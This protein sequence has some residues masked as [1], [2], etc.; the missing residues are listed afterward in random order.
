MNGNKIIIIIMIIITICLWFSEQLHE[1][2][3][4]SLA[5]VIC[6]N[7]DNIRE[8]QPLVFLD[9]DPFLWDLTSCLLHLMI[10]NCIS[11]TIN[12]ILENTQSGCIPVCM[13]L[14]YKIYFLLTFQNLAFSFTV[15]I[16]ILNYSI[17]I[18][19]R[20]FGSTA[21]IPNPKRKFSIFYCSTLS[22][23]IIWTV[24]FW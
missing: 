10:M 17:D 16:M 19:Q 8:V 11:L 24:P 3:K 21:Q 18:M 13:S 1:I 2:R 9:K 20:D 15:S 6:N 4:T 14:Q 23:L 22:S 5:R 7:A 12:L